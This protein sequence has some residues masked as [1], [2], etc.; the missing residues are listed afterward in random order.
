MKR[1]YFW[2]KF[3]KCYLYFHPISLILNTVGLLIISISSHELSKGAFQ[4]C[5]T[6]YAEQCNVYAYHTNINESLV[7]VLLAIKRPKL[8][9]LSFFFVIIQIAVKELKTLIER[10]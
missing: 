7:S 3:D 10:K 9:N 8:F 6:A 5:P 1:D 4:E 2:N